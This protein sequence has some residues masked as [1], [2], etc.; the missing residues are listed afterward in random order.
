MTGNSHLQIVAYCC[1]YCAYSA[2]DLA[3]GL[4]LQYPPEIKVVHLPCTGKFDVRMALH[5]LE[6]GADGVM[7]AGCLPGDCHFLEGNLNA[8]R[9]VEHVRGLLSQIGLEPDRVRMFNMSA[10]MAAEFVAAT[11]EMTEQIMAL[12]PSPLRL[13]GTTTTSKEA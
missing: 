6:D 3:G 13:E 5:A 1:K 4:R 8:R 12:G 2:A 11:K 10:A 7:V 9:R